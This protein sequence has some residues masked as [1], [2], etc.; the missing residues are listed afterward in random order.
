[1]GEENNTENPELAVDEAKIRRESLTSGAWAGLKKGLM[2]GG[3]AGFVL[4]AVGGVTVFTMLK[5]GVIKG[6]EIGASGLLGVAMKWP[7]VG[8]AA[9]AVA[10]LATYIIGPGA[11]A[12][13]A[14]AGIGGLM[15]GLAQSIG[16]GMLAIG[17][18]VMLAGALIG[19]GMGAMKGY[20]QADDKV[21]MAKRDARRQAQQA[22]LEKQQTL[23]KMRQA[24]EMQQQYNQQTR[25]MTNGAYANNSQIGQFS[26][27]VTPNTNKDKSLAD[28]IASVAEGIV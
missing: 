11:I 17:L 13:G 2:W 15:L 27:G 24:D 14:A 6:M 12:G 21:E 8:L 9:T 28:G 23:A 4:G 20:E 22:E 3:I 10:G 16:T 5:T 1:M 26:P 25:D 7:V 18:P 19:A